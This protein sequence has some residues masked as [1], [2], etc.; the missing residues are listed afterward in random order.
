MSRITTAEYLGISPPSADGTRT[1]PIT[2]KT[3]GGGRGSLFGGVGLAA[4]VI[5]LADAAGRPVVWATGQYV[6][7]LFEPATMELTVDLPA[8]GR[9]VTQG[10]VSGH[11]DD[12]EVITVLGAAGAREELYRGS[13]DAPPE[14]PAP[15]DC[16]DVGRRF[17]QPSIHY[18]TE[19]RIAR[20]MFG[21]T[22]VGSPSGDNR[23]VL[24][25]R[26]P[27]VA[28]DA[29]MLA[30]VA[31]FGPS[32]V[33]NAVGQTVS[34]TSLDNTIRYAEPIPDGSD[35]ILLDNRVEFVG[36]GFAKSSSL[37]WTESGVLLAT[38]SQSMTV[39]PMPEDL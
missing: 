5:A 20:G 24:W 1:L 16:Q 10:R 31:D 34:V 2:H 21:F 30:I 6:S 18:Y 15:E 25:T 35:W 36:N 29:A 3:N 38:A 8:V 26:M 37:I 33:G 39:I 19:V 32:A 9:S 17:E 13:W 4:G 12:K 14:A 7:T 11:H 28:P 23:T 22:G 27:E